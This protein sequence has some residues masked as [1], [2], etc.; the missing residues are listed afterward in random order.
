MKPSWVI[1]YGDSIPFE[2]QAMQKS[3]ELSEDDFV[4]IRYWIKQVKSYGP[5]SLRQT[6]K[7]SDFF[8]LNITD[9]ILDRDCSERNFWNDHDLFGI[10]SGYRSSSFSRLG[11]IIYKIE[12]EQ[13]KV[14]KVEKI[15]PNHSY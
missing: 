14:V 11:R 15:T 8:P 5:N 6:R 13:L 12:N 1:D 2:I 7:L 10:W 9:E 4:M 3:G